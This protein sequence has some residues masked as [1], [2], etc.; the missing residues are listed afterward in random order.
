MPLGKGKIVLMGSGELTAT[1]VEVHKAL[2]NDLDGPPRAVFID[3]PAGFQ[4]NVDQLSQRALEYFKSRVQHTMS[5]VS[6][7]SHDTITPYD[8]EQAF[9]S[10]RES[11]FILIGPGSPTYAVRQWQQTPIPDIISKRVTEGSCLVAA[12]AAALTV[13]RFTLPVYEIYKVG[14]TLHWIDG[15]DILGKFGMDFV[16]IPHWN[17]AEGGNHDTRFCYMGEPRFNTLS[18]N[19]P[20]DVS[21]LGLDEHTACIIDLA[22]EEI[23]IK[24]IGTVTLRRQGS[25]ITFS[26]GESYP[27]AIFLGEGTEHSFPL[28]SS[29]QPIQTDNKAHS[30]D[31]SFWERI[32]SI[33]S[34]FQDSLDT[35]D[36]EKATNALLELD[37]TIW[38]EQ[39]N[40]E[41]PE[42][43][44]QA[45]DALRDMI[46][47]FGTSLGASP[48][49]T[50]ESL[51]PVIEHLINL[52]NQFR[53]TKKWA[54]AD[55]IRDSLMKANIV[56]E[57]TDD[58]SRWH[59]NE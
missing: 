9:H 55:A 7:K 47:L 20:E 21:I 48:C 25:E 15:M 29:A 39:E 58:G 34:N 46:V 33:Q 36:P 16:V 35:N 11:D 37:G 18:T 6:F 5:V 49:N 41:N 4:L 50:A 59:V 42:F 32:H 17:N 2:L 52:R 30:S 40:L 56:I 54:E 53:Q 13:G 27:L 43:I 45:R 1:M 31:D 14:E 51:A 23:T 44:S 3:T 28:S 22:R 26:K 57:D 38:K 19:L 8:A 12:S 10:L 24:G